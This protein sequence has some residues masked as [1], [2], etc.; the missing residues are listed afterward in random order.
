MTCRS[1]N[2]GCLVTWFCYQKP[3]NKTAAVSWPD[4]YAV[5]QYHVLQDYLRS[6]YG[7]AE[8]NVKYVG[9]FE[10]RNKTHVLSHGSSCDGLACCWRF[11]ELIHY[12]TVLIFSAEKFLKMLQ[13][14]LIDIISMHVTPNQWS[15]KYLGSKIVQLFSQCIAC[16]WPS[17]VRC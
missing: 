10:M 9:A 3:G 8:T 7:M 14:I 11:R 16:W 6:W 4:P 12:K 17:V 1:R 5:P 13:T 15:P 2:C